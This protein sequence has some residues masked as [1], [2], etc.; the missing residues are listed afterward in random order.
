MISSCEILSGGTAHV[1]TAAPFFFLVLKKIT[2][3]SDSKCALVMR[4]TPAHR[5]IPVADP[6]PPVGTNGEP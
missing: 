4:S 6:R 2:G 3:P 1:P 5:G